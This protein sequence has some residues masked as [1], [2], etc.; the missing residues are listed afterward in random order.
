MMKK[1][2]YVKSDKIP[3]GLPVV[4]TA[5]YVAGER[6]LPRR[7][8][9]TTEQSLKEAMRY[10]PLFHKALEKYPARIYVAPD[11]KGEGKPGLSDVDSGLVKLAKI[12]MTSVISSDSDFSGGR[13][14][15]KRM[16]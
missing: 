8:F 4:D 11:I 6:D 10:G 1:I 7:E 12:Q 16:R 5:N 2:L 3:S 9:A 15:V 14:K 13:T